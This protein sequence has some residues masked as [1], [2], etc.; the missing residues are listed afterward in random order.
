M[1]SSR[2]T[3]VIEPNAGT[4]LPTVST[5]PAPSLF[6]TRRPIARP[7]AQP[8]AGRS[9]ISKPSPAPSLAPTPFDT[10]TVDVAMSVIAEAPP[11]EDQE[12]A[13]KQLIVE[14]IGAEVHNFVVVVRSARSRVRRT[15]RSLLEVTWEVSFTVSASLADTG[16]SS[17]DSFAESVAETLTSNEFATAMSNTGGLEGATVDEESV[18]TVVEEREASSVDDGPDEI[19]D[20]KKKDQDMIAKQKVLSKIQ[21]LNVDSAQGEIAY[22]NA[23]GAGCTTLP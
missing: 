22:L 2:P 21:D 16:D 3:P 4:V 19:E 14:Q 7:S 1:P 13:L 10:V 15:R 23:R 8:T 11:T 12:A 17:S 6:P 5:T 9:D 18:Q 20:Q